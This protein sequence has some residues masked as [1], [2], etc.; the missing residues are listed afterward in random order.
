MIFSLLSAAL[1]PHLVCVGS[2]CHIF[3]FQQHF[4]QQGNICY[5]ELLLPPTLVHQG[6]GK[7]QENQP[8]VS[9][10]GAEILGER[11]GLCTR[12]SG[13]IASS[14]CLSKAGKEGKA[15]AG[16]PCPVGHGGSRRGE[17]AWRRLRRR[18][19]PT[20]GM[21]VERAGYLLGLSGRAHPPRLFNPTDFCC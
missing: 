5:P 18:W 20:P 13:G 10:N 7:S 14:S 8:A 11:Q 9:Q 12:C 1:S 21:A 3:P 16:E 19:A 4:Q 15:E 17:R 2:C 6:L